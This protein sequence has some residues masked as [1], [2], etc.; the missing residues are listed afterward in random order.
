MTA[1]QKAEAWAEPR[2]WLNRAHRNAGI[3]GFVAGHAEGEREGRERMVQVIFDKF[4]NAEN[5]TVN[6]VIAAIRGE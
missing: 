2:L 4:S 5:W 6:D 1:Q 3:T